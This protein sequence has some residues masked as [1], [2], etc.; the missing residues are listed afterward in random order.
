MD[1]L[2]ATQY[3]PNVKFIYVD[4]TKEEIAKVMVPKFATTINGVSLLGTNYEVEALADRK[5]TAPVEE[6]PVVTPAIPEVTP[7]PAE[8]PV[9]APVEA[10]AE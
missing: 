2:E 7:T 3:I 8:A 4:V 6:A 1:F 10:K 9:E 5:L